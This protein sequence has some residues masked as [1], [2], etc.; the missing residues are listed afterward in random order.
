MEPDAEFQVLVSGVRAGTLYRSGEGSRFE[1]AADYLGQA[2]RPVLGQIFEDAPYKTWTTSQGV[3]NWFANLLPEG[4]LREAIARDVGVKTVR[5]LFLLDRLGGDLPGAVEIAR[6]HGDDSGPDDESLAQ[7]GEVSNLK[8]SLSGLQLKFSAT[9]VGRLTFAVS[10]V[11]GDLI[12]KFPDSVRQLVPENEYQAMTFARLSGVATPEVDLVSTTAF[13]GLPA[14][15]AQRG[16]ALVVR[17]F[18]RRAGDHRKVHIEDFAQLLDIRPEDKYGHKNGRG[19][20]FE[21]IARLA[22][23]NVGADVVPELVRRLVV[24]IAVGNGDAHNKNWSLIYRDQIRAELS[25]AYDIVPTVLYLPD[26]DLGLSIGGT[27]RFEEV[28]AKRFSRF[29]RRVQIDEGVVAEAVSHAVE[30]VRDAM[31]SLELDPAFRA[32]LND[33]IRD[34]PLFAGGSV[35]AST[36]GR[37]TSEVTESNVAESDLPRPLDGP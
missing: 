26:D 12:A 1:L 25:P 20:T 4:A 33:R 36:R 2:R 28:D 14:G 30:Q 21:T 22:I 17:R 8:F 37:N 16:S 5:D 10:G 18:D 23:G 7:P 31:S 6:V 29:A 3:P 34:L 24:N 27:K 9:R 13:Q 15:V 32:F 11:M 35:Q 19:K